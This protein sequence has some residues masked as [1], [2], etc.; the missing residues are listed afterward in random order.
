MAYLFRCLLILCFSVSAIFGIKCIPLR[1]IGV[2]DCNELMVKQDVCYGDKILYPLDN[3][4]M[5]SKTRK[6]AN[7][8]KTFRRKQKPDNLRKFFGLNQ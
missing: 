4:T 2:V 7:K 1:Q 3:V 8:V 5:S 6:I